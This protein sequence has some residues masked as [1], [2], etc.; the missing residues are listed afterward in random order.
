MTP[1]ESAQMK[2][3]EAVFVDECSGCHLMH[4]QGQ[5]LAFPP[6]AHSANVQQADPTT[7]L[8]LILAG[9]QASPTRAQP[10]P[11]TM[12]A[13]AWKLDDAQVA[14]VATYV[15]NNWGNA[16]PAVSPDQVARLRANLKFD[17]QASGHTKA[18]PLARPGPNTLGAPDTDSR[19]NGTPQ[20]G[21]AAPASDAPA[22]AASAGG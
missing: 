5:A 8:H 2:T 19:D 15:R 1:P 3:G 6:L 20:A 4:G 14:A 17:A 13:F 12:P 22:S 18:T 16:A 21:R 7:T 9:V 10:T 11:F